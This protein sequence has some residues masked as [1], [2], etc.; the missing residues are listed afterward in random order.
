MRVCRNGDVFPSAETIARLCEAVL[1][2]PSRQ[3]ERPG[4][5]IPLRPGRSSPRRDRSS[6]LALVV[7]A[8]S[9]FPGRTG[10]EQAGGRSPEEANEQRL[11]RRGL[12]GET[13]SQ[14]GSER[15]QV[16][17]NLPPGPG[18]RGERSGAPVG[19]GGAVT[20][21]SHR[22]RSSSDGSMDN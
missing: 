10:G 6:C 21:C 22:S 17:R 16:R 3:P 13:Y 12:G 9:T 14:E 5:S 15:P 18:G 1:T 4:G 20:R 8:G 19:P 7:K 11:S 2:C